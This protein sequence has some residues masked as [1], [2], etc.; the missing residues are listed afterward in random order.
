MLLPVRSPLRVILASVACG[1]LLTAGSCDV[2]PTGSAQNTGTGGGATAPR[3]N[4]G[5]GTARG[6]L[7][8]LKIANEHSMAGYSRDRFPHWNSQGD[9]CDTRD[10]VLKR[11]GK[12]VKT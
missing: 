9:G 8:Q 6:M 1:L 12:G 2:E 11:D 7:T 3:P 5:G 10:V 4:P